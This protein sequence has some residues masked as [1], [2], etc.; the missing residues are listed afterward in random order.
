[1]HWIIMIKTNEHIKTW[2][3]F[4]SIVRKKKMFLSYRSFSSNSYLKISTIVN[5]RYNH[6]S[7]IT[8]LKCKCKWPMLFHFVKNKWNKLL[9]FGEKKS[10]SQIVHVLTGEE[11]FTYTAA[12]HQEALKVFLLQLQGALIFI[13]NQWLKLN[14]L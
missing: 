13:H 9:S 7:L 3:S 11:G 1:M 4:S 10:F 6:G 14:K 8:A 12:C 5:H 2:V